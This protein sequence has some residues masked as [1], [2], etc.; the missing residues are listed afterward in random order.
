MATKETRTIFTRFERFWHWT[1]A[2]LI[3][4]MMATGFGIQGA[5]DLIPY[6]QAAEIHRLAAWGLMGLW[7]F[8]IFWHFTTGAWKHYI[9]TAHKLG[10][11]IRYYGVDIFN[12]DAE[13]PYRVTP[14]AKH[15]PL[16]RLAYLAF[17]LVIS[18]LIWVTGL[19]YMFHSA[20]PRLGIT[21]L[22]LQTVA[23]GHVL[24]AFMMLVFFIAHVYIAF[25]GRPW[26]KYLK[27]MITGRT[28]V[29]VE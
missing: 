3:V 18:P 4:G 20:W 7:V 10:A 6:A 11:M 26:S 27:A 22:D 12:T 2:L 17:K 29:Y 23:F 21:G 16:Q 8:A 13:P 9:P 25:T 5:H 15:N 1:Q 24:G 28:E 19:L 14:Q